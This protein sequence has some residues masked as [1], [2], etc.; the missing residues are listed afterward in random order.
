M[1]FDFGSSDFKSR[2]KDKEQLIRK[3]TASGIQEHINYKKIL[4][5]LR[6]YREER[7]ITGYIVISIGPIEI[8]SL[9]GEGADDLFATIDS[10]IQ[11]NENH[12]E[13]DKNFNKLSSHHQIILNTNTARNLYCNLS[14]Q[15]CIFIIDKDD[16]YYFVD[17]IDISESIFLTPQDKEGYRRLKG[18]NEINELFNEYRKYLKNR[19]VYRKFFLVKSHVKSLYQHLYS[20]NSVQVSEK[21][22]IKD[23]VQLLNNRPEDIFREDLRMFLKSNFKEKL[24]GKEYILENFKRLDIFFLDEYGELFFIE[25]KW[26]G[27]SIHPQGQRIE[28]EYNENNINPSAVL[29]TVGYIKELF[30]TGKNIKLGY[31]AV[32]DARYDDLSSDTV[33]DFD[34]NRLGTEMQKYYSRFVKVPDFRVKNMNPY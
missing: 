4:A 12:I 30:E 31:L 18:I 33:A 6:S 2:I 16:I 11:R 25:V 15:S 7:P 14:H 22:F 23:N 29:Q 8:E 17:G 13:V 32:F 21:E 34:K 26:V 28:T 20:S 9:K 1:S 5:L 3:K 27:K 19:D 24:L 10:L